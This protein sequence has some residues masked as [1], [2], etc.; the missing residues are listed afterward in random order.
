VIQAALRLAIIAGV[1]PG[2]PVARPGPGREKEGVK[3]ETMWGVQ[4]E[5]VVRG[6]G[7]EEEESLFRADAVNEEEE[8]EEEEEGSLFKGPR[9]RPR[10][11]GVGDETRRTT[12]L[13]ETHRERVWF[14][15][16]YRRG[17][18]Q[19]QTRGSR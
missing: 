17:H 14:I 4:R 5:A 8:E 11:P 18:L 16:R 19:N 7:E 6:G 9:A 13:R 15:E 3:R 1:T 12:L 2:E 10:Y